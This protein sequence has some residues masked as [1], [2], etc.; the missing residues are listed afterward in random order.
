MVAL[1]EFGVRN[2]KYAYIL[3]LK[4][5]VTWLFAAHVLNLTNCYQPAIQS[6]PQHWKS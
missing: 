6:M 5:P 4:R 3:K 1:T 2:H